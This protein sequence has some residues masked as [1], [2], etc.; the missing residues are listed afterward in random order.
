M[1]A[2][3]LP[4]K[5]L[6]SEPLPSVP[7]RPSQGKSLPASVDRFVRAIAAKAQSELEKA[8]HKAIADGKLAGHETV[9]TT[10]ELSSEKIGLSATIYGKIEL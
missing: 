10:V 5:P 9:S 3:P 4:T 7:E 8:V 6:Q 2:N 1:S